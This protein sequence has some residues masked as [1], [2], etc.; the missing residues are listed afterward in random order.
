MDGN[1]ALAPLAE[2]TDT[3]ALDMEL[4]SLPLL[5]SRK[6]KA[7]WDVFETKICIMDVVRERH[8]LMTT[9]EKQARHEVRQGKKTV[10]DTQAVKGEAFVCPK[11]PAQ[12]V[13]EAKQRQFDADLILA[14]TYVSLYCEIGR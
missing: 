12:L 9:E 13:Q 7:G 11:T 10:G 2:G 6:D 14:A 1:L 3:F 4:K 5:Y 8:R